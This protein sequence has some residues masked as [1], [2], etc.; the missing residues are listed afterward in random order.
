MKRNISSILDIVRNSSFNNDNTEHCIHI[1]LS[2]L[3]GNEMN[4]QE[5]YKE[6]M[7]TKKC[8]LSKQLQYKEFMKLKTNITNLEKKLLQILNDTDFM[9]EIILL[10][11]KKSNREN[12]YDFWRLMI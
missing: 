1:I 3:D 5:W 4:F 11:I 2:E 12:F 8:D 10:E 7:L 6:N 9:Q